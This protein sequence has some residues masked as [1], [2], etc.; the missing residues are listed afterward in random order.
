MDEIRKLAK[1]GPSLFNHS[2]RLQRTAGVGGRAQCPHRGASLVLTGRVKDPG[3]LVLGGLQ[4]NVLGLINKSKK[5][6]ID[7]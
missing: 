4:S 2:E 5:V 3:W 7:H 6:T 1:A